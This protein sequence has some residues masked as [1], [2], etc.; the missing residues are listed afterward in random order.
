MGT[1]KIIIA[2]IVL[3]LDGAWGFS[4]SVTPREFSSSTLRVASTAWAT[5]SNDGLGG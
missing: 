5:A 2:L 3:R 1:L 4:G